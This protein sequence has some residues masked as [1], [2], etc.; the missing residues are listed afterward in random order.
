MKYTPSVCGPTSYK[1]VY[2][3]S[4]KGNEV[5]R[6]EDKAIA[7]IYANDALGN[8]HVSQVRVWS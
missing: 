5:F 4:F 2:V 3:I 8:A 7:D 6:T 1:I